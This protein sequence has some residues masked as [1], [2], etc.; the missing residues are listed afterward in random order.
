MENNEAIDFSKSLG[1]DSPVIVI[2]E[3]EALKTEKR[4]LYVYMKS[5]YVWE[6]EFRN[7]KRVIEMRQ[8]IAPRL[9]G[10]TKEQL[11]EKLKQ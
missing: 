4:T 3:I 11:E 2:N 1:E 5:G 7:R 10:M 9:V 6:L 8:E